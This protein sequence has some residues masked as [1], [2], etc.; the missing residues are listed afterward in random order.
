[1]L[2]VVEALA[3][4]GVVSHR[5]P[6]GGGWIVASSVPQAELVCPIRAKHGGGRDVIGPSPLETLA[7]SYRK[8]PVTPSS[9]DSRPAS[10]RDISG[11][12][13]GSEP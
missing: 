6:P 3:L 9:R 7:T 1:M 8:N 2:R 12:S 10:R 5:S 13:P 4:G 11:G